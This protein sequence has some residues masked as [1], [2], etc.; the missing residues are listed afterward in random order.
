MTTPHPLVTA[1]APELSA[2]TLDWDAV[3]GR[4]LTWFDCPVGT[5]HLTGTDSS[6][7]PALFIIAASVRV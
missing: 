3:L 7:S 6:C 4:L 1:L 5:V 2:E